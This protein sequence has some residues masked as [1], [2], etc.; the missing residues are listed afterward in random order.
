M[1]V[2]L[3]ASALLVALGGPALRLVR[4]GQLNLSGAGL[5]LKSFWLNEAFQLTTPPSGDGS[6][7]MPLN[8]QALS[9]GTEAQQW[10]LARG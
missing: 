5:M 2:I 6:S 8:K 4:A 7:A 9:P 3:P 10:L 1:A